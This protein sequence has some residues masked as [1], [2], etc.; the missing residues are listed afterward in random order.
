MARQ[1]ASWVLTAVDASLFPV[2]SNGFVILIWIWPQPPITWS[3]GELKLSTGCGLALI[4]GLETSGGQFD[5]G[6]HESA[7]KKIPHR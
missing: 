4:R 5:T 7:Q 2:H 6:H 3:C 1:W